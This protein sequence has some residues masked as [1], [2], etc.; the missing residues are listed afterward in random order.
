[1][2]N[3][4]KF[5][6]SLFAFLAAVALA[7]DVYVWQTSGNP[8]AFAALGWI[9]KHY[10]GEEHK[11]V[12]ETVSPE[13]FNDLFTPFLSLPLFF[14]ML[15]L[16]VFSLSVGYLAFLVRRYSRKGAAEKKVPASSRGVVY[17]RK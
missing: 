14:S 5:F 4:S 13:I 3:V 7:H 11:V 1:M 16:S 8:F 2:S 10:A 15:G 12:V 17:R 9:T 6:A